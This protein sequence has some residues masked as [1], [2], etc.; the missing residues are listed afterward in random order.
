MHRS[1]SILQKSDGSSIPLQ[2][3][4]SHLTTCLAPHL[5]ISHI[6]NRR[7]R[8]ALFRLPP[9]VAFPATFAL[10]TLSS[11]PVFLNDRWRHHELQISLNTFPVSLLITS[12]V[13]Q[14]LLSTVLATLLDPPAL[15]ILREDGTFSRSSSSQSRH[16]L[17]GL[18]AESSVVFFT[19]GTSGTPKPVPLTL[20]SIQLQ[21]RFKQHSL[22]L[23]PTSVYLHLAPLYHL[24]GFSSSHAAALSHA[25]HV[26][27]P[28]AL[29]ATEK[30]HAQALLNFARAKRVTHLVA[31][32]ATLQLLCD[33]AQRVLL[34]DVRVV[35]YGGARAEAPLVTA[36]SHLCPHATVLGAYG[37]SETAS[38]VIVQQH[39]QPAYILP[40]FAARIVDMSTG[41]SCRPGQRGELW[42]SGDAVFDGYASFP[43]RARFQHG[44][45]RTG[46]VVMQNEDG[47]VIVLGRVADTIRSA[48]ETVWPAEVEDALVAH[49]TVKEAIVVGVPHRVLGEAVV[50]AVVLMVRET[51]TGVVNTLM[52]TCRES[53]AHYKCP[54]RIIVTEFLPRNANG[55]VSRADVRRMFAANSKAARL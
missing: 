5:H 29:H 48:G 13:E 32:P 44:F 38:S 4:I 47:S 11:T 10:H 39:P 8:V 26:F 7:H 54:K 1:L 20:R 17:P 35:L 50:A 25:H 49:P 21:S 36:L 15:L 24:S 12:P 19:S 3:A 31:V 16:N 51:V 34:P 2:H 52:K 6:S 46:D 45:F 30:S 42:L 14:R 41:R 55:K 40:H 37:M 33:A 28:A 43:A 22:R 53:L 23:T 18:P 9:Q 27:P